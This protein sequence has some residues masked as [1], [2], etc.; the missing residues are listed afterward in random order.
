MRPIESRRKFM[1]FY[2]HLVCKEF[3]RLPL[4]LALITASTSV[5]L[6]A[7]PAQAAGDEEI[8]KLDTMSVTAEQANEADA[9]QDPQ[10]SDAI[11]TDTKSRS[12]FSLTISV[13]KPPQ[14][15]TVFSRPSWKTAQRLRGN[16]REEATPT[17]SSEVAYD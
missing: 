16:S 8:I 13:K 11:F 1:K 5:S 4:T 14:S 15:V 9:Q 10:Y 2:E 3:E 12:S 7:L 6:I 17:P